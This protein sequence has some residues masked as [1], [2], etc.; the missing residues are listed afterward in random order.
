MR[1]SSFSQTG[2]SLLELVFVA[3]LVV[4][5]CAVAVP[6]I[7]ATL[8]ESRTLGAVRYVASRLQQTRMEAVA[9]TADVAIR[10]SQD[11][12]SYVFTTF[13]D[14]NADGV[15]SADIQSG[16]DRAIGH[17]ERLVDH[18]PGIEFGVLPALPPVDPS[19]TAPGNDPI[20][21]GSSDI[22]TFTAMGTSTP[23]SL[24]IVGRKG[25]QFVIRV[26]GETGKTRVLRFDPA[27]GHWVS[28]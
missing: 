7:L 5:S 25:T 27:S 11:P 15:R 26:F 18:F 17:D 22:V 24:Y 6:A 19:G 9:R 12:R 10:F 28:L 20:K 1:T 4:T 8:E 23:G 2:S 14:G 16:V 3:S 13:V 21:F